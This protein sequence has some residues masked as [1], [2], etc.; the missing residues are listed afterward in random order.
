MNGRICIDGYKTPNGYEA[1]YHGE[2]PDQNS[3]VSVSMK[4][5][6]NRSVKQI[7]LLALDYVEN[8][9]GVEPDEDDQNITINN[10]IQF[11]R[12]TDRM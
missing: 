10:V 6:C 8:C 4:I 3:I 11:K 5:H 12:P 1:R 7:L 9:I 2:L